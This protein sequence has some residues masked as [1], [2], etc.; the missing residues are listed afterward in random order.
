[1]INGKDAKNDSIII[2]IGSKSNN[3]SIYFPPSNVVF[4][5][6][7][8]SCPHSHLKRKTLLLIKLDLKVIQHDGQV[9]MEI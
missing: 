3:L 2:M 4:N 7:V 9:Y 6:T 5:N 1:M 8:N